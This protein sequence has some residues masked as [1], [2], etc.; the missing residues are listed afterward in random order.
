VGETWCRYAYATEYR[1]AR[2]IVKLAITGVGSNM[3]Y[4]EVQRIVREWNVLRPECR[5]EEGW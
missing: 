1:L 5:V 2:D 3:D 4:E